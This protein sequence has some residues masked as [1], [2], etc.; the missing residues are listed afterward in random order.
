MQIVAFCIK[1]SENNFFTEIKHYST[2]ESFNSY[3][4]NDIAQP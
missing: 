4:D 2:E 3:L 1:E